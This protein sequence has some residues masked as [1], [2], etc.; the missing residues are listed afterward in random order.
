M[1]AKAKAIKI[2]QI[3]SEA[4]LRAHHQVENEVLQ[5][6]S[7]HRQLKISGNSTINNAS[8]MDSLLQFVSVII[9]LVLAFLLIFFLE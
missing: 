2:Q 5:Y 6:R 1:E 8:I 4:K 7:Q 3:Y 9:I